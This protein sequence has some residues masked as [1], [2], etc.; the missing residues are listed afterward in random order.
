V[1]KTDT[2]YEYDP[3][4]TFNAEPS[5]YKAIDRLNTLQAF[6]NDF[7]RQLG[8]S[9]YWYQSSNEESVAQKKI[10]PVNFEGRIVLIDPEDRAVKCEL[11][12]DGES[13]FGE[14]PVS[15]FE[16]YDIPI[17]SGQMFNFSL[18]TIL[19]NRELFLEPLFPEMD[20]EKQNLIDEIMSL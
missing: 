16:Q 10:D 12:K 15:L 3:K 17:E 20:D 13:S 9:I 7:S 1:E 8:N 18:R 4:I 14:I 6:S 2:A 11:S 19:G 5:E